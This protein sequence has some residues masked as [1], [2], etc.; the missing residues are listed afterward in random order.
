M[1]EEQL[2]LPPLRPPQSDL[3]DVQYLHYL[4]R[5]LLHTKLALVKTLTLTLRPV[6]EFQKDTAALQED[7][8]HRWTNEGEPYARH[9][10]TLAVAMIL[11]TNALRDAQARLGVEH[12][13]K[14][15]VETRRRE[16]AKLKE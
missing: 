16:T 12:M 6:D 15:Q 4:L 9:M 5:S 2:N 1:T 7:Q 8:V 10:H 3:T 13:L 14:I 11:V